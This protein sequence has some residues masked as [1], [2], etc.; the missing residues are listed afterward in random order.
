LLFWNG[1]RNFEYTDIFI[2][3]IKK[4]HVFYDIGANIGYYPLL[5]KKENPEIKALDSLKLKVK[6][7]L[8]L[9]IL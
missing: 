9:V 2:K 6:Q 1:H 8:I 5:A 7:L 3:L 4:V